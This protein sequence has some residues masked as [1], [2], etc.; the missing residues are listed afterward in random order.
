MYR[1]RI[2]LTVTDMD[3]WNEAIDA[4]TEINKVMERLGQPTATIWTDTVGVFNQL[5]A[6]ID[7]VDLA[8]YE[9]ANKAF[10]ANEE[11]LKQLPRINHASVPGKGYTELLETTSTI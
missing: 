6:E 8:S 4:M 3:G 5:V 1:E 9:A 2:H 10:Y 11:I 7:H